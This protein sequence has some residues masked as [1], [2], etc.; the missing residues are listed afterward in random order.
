MSS[1]HLYQNE[2]NRPRR[3]PIFFHQND[4]KG[5]K[6]DY[7]YAPDHFLWRFGAT[8]IKKKKKT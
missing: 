1:M 2:Y 3:Y 7:L 5:H 6:R 8:G 4:R